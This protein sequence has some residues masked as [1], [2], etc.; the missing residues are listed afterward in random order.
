VSISRRVKIT[1]A[2]GSVRY[3]DK[4]GKRIRDNISMALRDRV[5]L[6]DHG[7]CRYCCRLAAPIHLDHVI[8]HSK[9]GESTFDNLVVSCIACN[10]RKRD[11][12]W[13]PKAIRQTPRPP[14]AVR[15]EAPRRQR[16]DENLRKREKV[17]AAKRQ[18][19]HSENMALRSK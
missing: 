10:L 8:P 5:V 17:A 18:A 11:R 3:V 7:I 15:Q 1:S 16:K 12:I 6:R 14:A 9:G 19:L 2:D 13:K 4:N